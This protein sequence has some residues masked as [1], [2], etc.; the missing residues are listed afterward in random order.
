M[1]YYK[2]KSLKELPVRVLNN[3]MKYPKSHI[4]LHPRPQLTRPHFMLLDG[5]WDFAFDDLDVEVNI[6]HLE[7]TLLHLEKSDYET[8]LWV[9]GIHVGH[10]I[11]G[12]HRLSFDLTH[13]LIQDQNDIVLR[14]KDTWDT[15]QPRG[16]QRWKG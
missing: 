4:D 10:E 11:G 3:M 2:I 5:L 14:I 7:K 15:E 1:P 16:K 9:N 12:Y 8:D 6:K 13:A